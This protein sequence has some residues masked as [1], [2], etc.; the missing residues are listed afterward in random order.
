MNERNSENEWMKKD[1]DIE[2]KWKGNEIKK[3]K[4]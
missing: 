3:E 2:I 4:V 1:N